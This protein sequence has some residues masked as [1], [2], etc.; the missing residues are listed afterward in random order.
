M[1]NKN[2]FDLTGRVAIVTGGAGLLGAEHAVAL[3]DFGATVV[4][5]DVNKEKCAQVVAQLQENGVQNITSAHIDVTSKASWEA[6]R[7]EVV[8]VHGRIDILIN[9]AAFTNQSKSANY[10]ATFENFPL[11]D[12]N[13][14]M[15]VNLTGTFLGCQVIGTHMLAA[16]KGAIVNIASLYG[17]VSPNHKIYPGTGIFQ[18]AAYSVSKHGVVA[19]TKYLGTL[20]AEKGVKVN[21]LT[22]GGV[23]NNH[24]GLFFERYK[25]LNPSGRM[26]DKSEM[27]GG[28]VYLVSDASSHV[29]G[30][31]LIVDGGWSVW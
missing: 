31:N 18:P 5:A 12:W 11:E 2:L 17:I 16:G 21:A 9:N 23:F 20:W 6:L 3:T 8:S 14:I 27:R 4:L 19:F 7:D 13:A 26:A 25:Q 22:P 15:N 1:Q 29:V 28:I 10:E 24:E 30:H